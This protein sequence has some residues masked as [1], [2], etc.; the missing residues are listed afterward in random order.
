MRGRNDEPDK[1]PLQFSLRRMLGVTLAAAILMGLAVSFRGSR[2]FHAF[3]SPHALIAALPILGVF[4]VNATAVIKERRLAFLSLAI[5]GAAL[6]T[7]ALRLASDLTFGYGAFLLSFLG[8]GLFSDW[9]SSGERFWYPI[10]C[11]MGALAN[12]SFIVGY[13]SF[14]IFVLWRKGIG[15]ARWSSTLGSCL[16]LFVI[17]PLALSTELNGVYVGYGLWAASLLAL[18][19]GSWRAAINT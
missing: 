6:A 4:G 5:Y 9:G 17:L 13:V 18:E 15:L 7:P 19:L 1:K 3:W 14:L 11:T 8:I 16:S 10:A 2:Y 12:V